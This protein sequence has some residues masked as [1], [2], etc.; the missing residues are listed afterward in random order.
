ML[1]GLNSLNAPIISVTTFPEDAIKQLSAVDKM[2]EKYAAIITPRNPTGST[3]LRSIGRPVSGSG[4]AKLSTPRYRN[5]PWSAATFA[6]R[7]KSTPKQAMSGHSNKPGRYQLALAVYSTLIG[8]YRWL[9]VVN[10][11]Q[12]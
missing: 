7:P 5:I 4:A 11:N 2:A 12:R 3:V 9:C 1:S 6:K 10:K 8:S